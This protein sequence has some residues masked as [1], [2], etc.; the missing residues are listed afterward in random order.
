MAELKQFKEVGIIA[1]YR[2]QKEE[3]RRLYESQYK[4][5]FHYVKDVDINTV[6]AFQ[7]RETDIIF[8]SVVRSNDEGKLGFLQDVRRLNVAFS[9]ARELLVVVGNHHSV[10]KNIRLHNE[11][12]P[13]VGIVTYIYENGDDCLL[14]EVE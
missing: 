12:N 5:R 4:E 7:G 6:D 1:G 14:K 9:R 13:F 2:E 11:E 10:T 3:L 8:Y